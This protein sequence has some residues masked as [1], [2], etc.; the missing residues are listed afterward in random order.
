MSRAR[1]RVTAA[2]FQAPYSAK[3]A[4]AFQSAKRSMA[5]TDWVMVCSSTFNAKAVTHSAKRRWPGRVKAQ[6]KD[7]SSDCQMDQRSVACVTGHL[8][9]RC[10]MGG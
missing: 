6:A 4:I 10:Q 7:R 3:D 5:V 8:L 9:L 2:A 1:L